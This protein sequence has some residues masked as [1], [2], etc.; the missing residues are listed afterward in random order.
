MA[1]LPSVEQNRTNQMIEQNKTNPMI[2]QNKQIQYKNQKP[3]A[4]CEMCVECVGNVLQ[5][6]NVL[7]VFEKGPFSSL[8]CYKQSGKCVVCLCV[9]CL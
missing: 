8:T 1:L 6:R 2:Q 4:K 7:C 5:M 9:V 3:R